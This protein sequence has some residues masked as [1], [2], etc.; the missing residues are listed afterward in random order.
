MGRVEPITKAVFKIDPDPAKRPIY[1]PI[2]PN[3]SPAWISAVRNIHG[4]PL[5]S[6]PPPTHDDR[7]DAR[8]S[9]REVIQQAHVTPKWVL[10]AIDKGSQIITPDAVREA[11]GKIWTSEMKLIFFGGP[12]RTTTVSAFKSFL[13][14]IWAHMA[15]YT[16]LYECRNFAALF[17]SI[18]VMHGINAVIRTLDTN[19]HHSYIEIVLLDDKTLE[20]LAF[21][22][23]PQ[24]NEFVPKPYPQHG[25][26]GI[27][28]GEVQ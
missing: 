13:P 22:I 20:A 1:G 15:R 21:V 9:P 18:C 10:D 4:D 19:G 24:V 17:K 28:E 16:D 23:E 6:S 27:G 14:Y 7:H 12:I 25:Y 8:P 26:T 5:H 3:R 11:H 2:I